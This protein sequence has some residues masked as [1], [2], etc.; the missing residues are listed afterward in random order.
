[1]RIHIGI[2][3][4]ECIDSSEQEDRQV[5]VLS[6]VLYIP[7]QTLPVERRELTCVSVIERK[8]RLPKGL[9]TLIVE[10]NEIDIGHEACIDQRDFPCLPVVYLTG[11][12]QY[13]R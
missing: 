5:P 10:A 1:M 9:I 4:I 12:W 7:Y 13:R 11:S 8:Q 6:P 3:Q 2:D